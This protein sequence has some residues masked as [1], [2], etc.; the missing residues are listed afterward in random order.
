MT[1][2][3]WRL[4]SEEMGRYQPNLMRRSWFLVIVAEQKWLNS[5]VYGRYNCSYN[6]VYRATNI[7]VDGPAKS[8]SPV[9]SSEVFTSH[10]FVG[11]EK[12]SKIGG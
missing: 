2:L 10:D 1:S 8:E 4:V 3:C 5:I 11:V 7:T 6:G 9:E 12:P